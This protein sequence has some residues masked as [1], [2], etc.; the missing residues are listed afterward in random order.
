[1]LFSGNFHRSIHVYNKLQLQP[2]IQRCQRKLPAAGLI[3]H[4]LD[5][6]ML[7]VFFHIHT[8][9]PAAQPHFF[10]LRK[11][12]IDRIQLLQHRKRNLELLRHKAAFF[13]LILHGAYRPF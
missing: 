10:L 9:D 11:R 6:N 5:I 1:M 4:D 12:D 3:I 7:P 13:E 2:V 8:V